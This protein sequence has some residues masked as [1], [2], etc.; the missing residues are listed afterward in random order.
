M[1]PTTGNK[2]ALGINVDGYYIPMLLSYHQK[3]CCS[4]I[5]SSLKQKSRIQLPAVEARPR[6]RRFLNLSLT[7]EQ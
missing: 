6:R 7:I 5:K 3:I 1:L 4:I 2:L